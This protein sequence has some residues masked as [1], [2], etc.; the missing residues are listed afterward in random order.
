MKIHGVC[1]HL[2]ITETN[3]FRRVVTHGDI[4]TD[5]NTT[6][7]FV[8]ASQPFAF[9]PTSHQTQN[10]RIQNL[11]N[12]VSSNIT[13]SEKL[14]ARAQ[15]LLPLAMVIAG[16]WLS[17]SVSHEAQA[18]VAASPQPAS[19]NHAHFLYVL[20]KQ[21]STQTNSNETGKNSTPQKSTQ[22]IS[23]RIPQKIGKNSKKK[24]KTEYSEEFRRFLPKDT[25]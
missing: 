6:L 18:P 7:I 21:A 4:V 14:S 2:W 24:L 16:A 5:D 25:K 15:N 1:N 19:L 13:P 17:V 22:K 20:E 10:L 23:T 9:L 3:Q 8:D 12:A 11:P